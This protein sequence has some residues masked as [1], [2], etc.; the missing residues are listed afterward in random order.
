MMACIRSFETFII[1]IF[2]YIFFTASVEMMA[3]IRS[4]EAAE[5]RSE[6]MTC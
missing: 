4:L 3:R 6:P 2:L 5:R 1:I